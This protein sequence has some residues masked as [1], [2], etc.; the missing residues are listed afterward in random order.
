VASST[1]RWKPLRM[2]RRS[3]GQSRR[4]RRPSRYSVSS[5]WR[6][7][8]AAR[9]STASS[10]RSRRTWSGSA[11]EAGRYCTSATPCSERPMRMRPSGDGKIPKLTMRERRSASRDASCAR[12]S[13]APS[14]RSGLRRIVA[15]MPSSARYCARSSRHGR[16]S[17]T[18]ASTRLAAAGPASPAATL[19]RSGSMARHTGWRGLMVGTPFPPGDGRRGRGAA[20]A[21]PGRRGPA[22]SPPS[23]PGS[24]RSPRSPARASFS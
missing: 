16:H 9:S 19:R 15:T 14:S 17:A 21:G 3:S 18:W 22:R 10:P 6:A 2:R 4:A 13:I 12:A 11:P 24:R 20:C 23:T 8:V 5:A 1:R 7:S